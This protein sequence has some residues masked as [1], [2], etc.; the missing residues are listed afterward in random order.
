MYSNASTGSQHKM[1]VALA[2]GVWECQI[3]FL[4]IFEQIPI[5]RDWGQ[6]S[7]LLFRSL[8]TLSILYSMIIMGQKQCTG[9][10]VQCVFGAFCILYTC[11]CFSN[12]MKTSSSAINRKSHPFAFRWTLTMSFTEAWNRIEREK[13][14]RFV[15]FVP[16]TINW[17]HIF[18]GHCVSTHPLFVLPTYLPKLN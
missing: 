16:T 14:D 8:C 1:F 10:E 5:V 12:F 15:M 6:F 11:D 7:S 4:V 17:V 9:K 2:V 3:L 13:V 18:W